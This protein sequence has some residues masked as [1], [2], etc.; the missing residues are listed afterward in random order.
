MSD[1]ELLDM[2]A[3]AANYEVEKSSSGGYPHLLVISRG[4]KGG[5]YK[6]EWDPLENDSDALRLAVKLRLDVR[7]GSADTEAAPYTSNGW[8]HKGAIESH[9]GDSLAATRRAIVR[10]AAEMA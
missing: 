8:S 7:V 5:I 6:T 2:A 1:V 4:R 10:A 3:K 9:A